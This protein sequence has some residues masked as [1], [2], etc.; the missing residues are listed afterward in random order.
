[1]QTKFDVD[2]MGKFIIATDDEKMFDKIYF[3]LMAYGFGAS[4]LSIARDGKAPGVY[5]DARDIEDPEQFA[6]ELEWTFH[7]GDGLKEYLIETDRYGYTTGDLYN[8]DDDLPDAP[9]ISLGICCCPEEA[10]WRARVHNCNVQSR[11]VGNSPCDDW[12]IP[13]EDNK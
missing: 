8:D 11:M 5:I 3:M 6:R 2:V 12:Y 10:H 1:M 9:L 13:K 4:Q 7:G